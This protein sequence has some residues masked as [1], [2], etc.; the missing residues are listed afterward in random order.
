MTYR[1]HHV[2]YV[3]GTT[4]PVCNTSEP[5][6]ER[7]DGNSN[8]VLS[9]AG[10]L[11]LFVVSLTIVK[12]K[13]PFKIEGFFQGLQSPSIPSPG[14]NAAGN[15]LLNSSGSAVLVAVSSCVS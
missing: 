15:S 13:W 9:K 5:L 8:I 3:S 14:A 4:F 2:L 10:S 6:Q 1:F 12:K 7:I 11:W